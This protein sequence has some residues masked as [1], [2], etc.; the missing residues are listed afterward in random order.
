MNLFNQSLKELVSVII[1]VYNTENFLEECLDS[2]CTQTYDKLEIILVND[3]S[4]DYSEQ[5][6]NEYAGKDNRIKVINKKNTGISDTRNV[7]ICSSHGNW[8]VFL[9]SDD[10]LRDDA[11]EVLYRTAKYKGTKMVVGDYQEFDT[12]VNFE[13]DRNFNVEV[14]SV[15]DTLEELL[16]KQ[17]GRWVTTW[18]KIYDRNLFE[19][20]RFPVGQIGRA[21]V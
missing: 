14:L 13:N 19:E 3:G 20:I 4:T 18:A 15:E 7:G 9:D 5:I 6:C 11:I 12:Y 8:L 17:P 2:V 16:I 10:V 1:P 21:H